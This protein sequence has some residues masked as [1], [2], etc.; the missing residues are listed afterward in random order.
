MIEIR[1]PTLVC[2]SPMC[3]RDNK[4]GREFVPRAEKIYQC[5][6]CRDGKYLFVKDDVVTKTLTDLINNSD[7]YYY[8]RS[9]KRAIELVREKYVR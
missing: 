3:T 4:E 7:G 2:K 6:K 5:S 8:Q 9:L 1:L